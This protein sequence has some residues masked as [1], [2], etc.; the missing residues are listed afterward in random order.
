[1]SVPKLTKTYI[2]L[3]RQIVDLCE[4][5]AK[6][7]VHT[8]LSKYKSR[9]QSNLKKIIQD[10]QIGKLGEFAVFYLLD[11]CSIPDLKIYSA[12]NKKFSADLTTDKYNIHV[13]TQSSKSEEK[14]GT[15]W[16]FQKEDKIIKSSKDN[17]IFIGI[18]YIEA[19][20]ACVIELIC[21]VNTLKFS[22][23]KISKLTTKLAVELEN[24]L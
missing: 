23:P 17:D 14:F 7:C 21:P 6:N 1:M 19:L 15:G 2:E 3:N 10:I 22:A 20:E 18:V 9:N 5:F 12:K 11:G 16:M 24:N 4:Q 8:N 13:K